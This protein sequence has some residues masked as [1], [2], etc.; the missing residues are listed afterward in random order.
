MLPSINSVHRR[1]LFDPLLFAPGLRDQQ[2]TDG[3]LDSTTC[4]L[5]ITAKGPYLNSRIVTEAK[6]LPD[7]EDGQWSTDR[8]GE[9]R[10]KG[11]GVQ[12]L[13]NFADVI[14]VL[15]TRPSFMDGL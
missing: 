6:Y 14:E 5:C 3:N 11:E 9:M 12:N 7:L 13:N 1:V 2:K 10:S 4:H 8:L 15:F